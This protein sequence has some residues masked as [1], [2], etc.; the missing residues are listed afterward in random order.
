MF[1]LFFLK[2]EANAN[3][4]SSNDDFYTASVVEFT[5]P[6][7]PTQAVVKPKAMIESTLNE[8][9]NLINEAKENGAD[10]IVFPEGTLNYIG[11]ATRNIL[12]KHAV[13]LN[14]TDIYNSTTF[15]NVCDYA[16]KSQVR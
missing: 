13:E 5:A 6:T 3:F 1:S 14:D 2:F 11:M 8:Y 9:L 10:I 15:T 16:K 7:S 12:I 4:H